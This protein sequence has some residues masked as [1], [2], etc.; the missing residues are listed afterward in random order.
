MFADRSIN[1]FGQTVLSVVNI[2]EISHSKGVVV[3]FK[4]H[5]QSNIPISY[6]LKTGNLNMNIEGQETLV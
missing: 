5:S 4:S 3:G 1:L 2:K 6:N